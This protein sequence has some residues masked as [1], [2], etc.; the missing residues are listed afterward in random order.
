[1]LLARFRSRFTYANVMSTVAL[2]LA[3]GGG[4]YAAATVGA[5]DI[6]QDAVRSR[7]IKNHE[8]QSRD[9]RNHSLQGR[10]V[11]NGSLSGADVAS[12]SL[13]GNQIAGDSLF[14]S[15]IVESTLATVPSANTASS[16]TQADSASSVNGFNATKLHY[17]ANVPDGPTTL[18]SNFHGVSVQ[19]DCQGSDNLAV[20]VLSAENNWSYF[21]TG[22]AAHALPATSQGILLFA[23]A[24]PSSGSGE[25]VVRLPSGRTVT[26]TWGWYLNGSDSDCAFDAVAFGSE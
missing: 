19:A 24:D 21:T 8:V 3:L 13:T 18:L 4:A 17:R 22:G 5:R 2:F 15:D 20:R 25:S 9:V 10:D 12:S 14:G 6:E 26:F 16:A 7:H 23:S 11:Q 1:M